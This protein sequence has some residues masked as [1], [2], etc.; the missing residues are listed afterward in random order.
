MDAEELRRDADRARDEWRAANTSRGSF[1]AGSP[2]W[3]EADVLAQHYLAEY[4]RIFGEWRRAVL[5][6]A[7]PPR[8]G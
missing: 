7:V 5:D 3:V 1:I 4:R 8:E 6:R 2:E